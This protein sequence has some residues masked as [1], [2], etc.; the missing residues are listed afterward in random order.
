M[1]SV[2]WTCHLT[3][4]SVCI[5]GWVMGNK[6]QKI[7]SY[8][9]LA[10]TLF[11]HI[12][13]ILKYYWE[14][15]SPN[16]LLKIKDKL[17]QSIGCLQVW[18]ILEICLGSTSWPPL[19]SSNTKWLSLVAL[20]GKRHSEVSHVLWGATRQRGPCKTQLETWP[21]DRVLEESALTV[22]CPVACC[23]RPCAV[24][25]QHRGVTLHRQVDTLSFFCLQTPFLSENWSCPCSIIWLLCEIVSYTHC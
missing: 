9:P 22:P 5:I 8:S 10:S 19:R 4:I 25:R 15:I 23:L 11:S 7:R 20:S 14:K 1:Y 3:D 13:W 2:L 12:I 17:L 21:W 24:N 16:L 18:E 6:G